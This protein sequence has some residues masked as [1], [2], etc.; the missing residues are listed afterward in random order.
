MRIN[1]YNKIINLDKE[2]QNI[3]KLI[4]KKNIISDRSLFSRLNQYI[5]KEN[6]YA[7]L[8]IEFYISNNKKIKKYI[9]LLEKISNKREIALSLIE[10]FENKKILEVIEQYKIIELI[11]KLST[12]NKIEYLGKEQ[13]SK[14]K[15]TQKKYK[16]ETGLNIGCIDT[17]NKNLS[18]NIFELKNLILTENF[19][20]KEELKKSFPE[21]KNKIK[22]VIK[23]ITILNCS[24]KLENLDNVKQIYI[25]D[26]NI[27]QINKKD[28]EQKSDNDISIKNNNINYLFFKDIE[29]KNASLFIEDNIIIEDKNEEITKTLYMKK[30]KSKKGSFISFKNNEISKIDIENSEFI[31]SIFKIDKNNKN[32]YHLSFYKN[33]C[34]SLKIEI[35]STKD[36]KIINNKFINSTLKT[37][38]QNPDNY[39]DYIKNLIISYN[40]LK[41]TRF[42]IKEFDIKYLIVDN[43][44]ILINKDIQ[45]K[46]FDIKEY[47]L[48]DFDF[49]KYKNQEEE[50]EEITKNNIEIEIFNNKNLNINF[51]NKDLFEFNLNI[52][53]NTIKKILLNKIKYL[54]L[55][56]NSNKKIN[57]IEIDNIENINLKCNYNEISIFK[58]KKIKNIEEFD[59]SFSNI[60]NGIDI[61]NRKFNCVPNLT[62]TSIKTKTSVN[63]IEIKIKDNLKDKDRLRKLK[64]I[65]EE[66][67][68]VDSILEYNALELITKKTN[69]ISSLVIN[70]YFIVSNF[71]K[72]IFLPF[73]WWFGTNVLF[74]YYYYRLL[75]ISECICHQEI[76]LTQVI[77]FSF[78]NS[79]SF[80]QILR[81][82]NKMFF[83]YFYNKPEGT[84]NLLVDMPWHHMLA[85]KFHILLS[86]VF[87]FLMLLGVRNR[88]RIK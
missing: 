66:N 72:S 85:I 58:N 10:F 38:N 65:A 18:V 51:E 13:E 73:F 8:L 21:I 25:E 15:E 46:D 77:K 59:V 48:M 79:V 9:D 7:I 43:N 44:E 82:P 17:P 28:M 32:C 11:K 53:N 39:N 2:K 80:G 75:N 47:D 50:E 12:K 54:N 81:N 33:F 20:F 14:S 37:K 62:N 3:I 61:S 29:I 63:N 88:F 60:E 16:E 41:Y 49:K 67:K 57:E 83:E 40:I 27:I 74:S 87:I 70:F 71:G 22:I 6:F 56:V 45:E 24:L 86:A 64:E 68:D 55:D 4:N 42:S 26:V 36:L 34:K 19:D 31:D 84:F 52:F 76:Y 35:N 5:Y 30:I 23:R 78:L 1:I 69:F